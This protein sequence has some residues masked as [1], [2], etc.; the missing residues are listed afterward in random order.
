VNAAIKVA[1]IQVAIRGFQKTNI[2]KFPRK[3][4]KYSIFFLKNTKYP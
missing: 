2:S 4:E 3:F 1:G